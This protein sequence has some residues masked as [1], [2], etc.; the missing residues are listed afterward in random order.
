[1]KEGNPETTEDYEAKHAHAMSMSMST[2]DQLHHAVRHLMLQR[3]QMSL[4]AVNCIWTGVRPQLPGQ[5]HRFMLATLLAG[6]RE[7]ALRCPRQ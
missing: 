1:M 6:A 7:L 3:L 5:I 2:A 4:E